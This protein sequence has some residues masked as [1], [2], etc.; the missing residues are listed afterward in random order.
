MPLSPLAGLALTGLVIGETLFQLPCIGEAFVRAAIIGDIPV[1]QGAAMLL[2]GA[3]AGLSLIA[4]I[5][6]SLADS[7]VASASDL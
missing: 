1:V 7:R 5:A 2:V 6:Y 4:D 3:V